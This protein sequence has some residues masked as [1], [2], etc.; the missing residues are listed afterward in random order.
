MLEKKRNKKNILQSMSVFTF[1][2]HNCFY[3]SLDLIKTNNT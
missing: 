1:R 2:I 3:F